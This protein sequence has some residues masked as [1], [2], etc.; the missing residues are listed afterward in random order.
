MRITR[1]SSRR[2]AARASATSSDWSRRSCRSRTS[3]RVRRIP[4]RALKSARLID[5][6]SSRPALRLAPATDERSSGSHLKSALFI[7]ERAPAIADNAV[8]AAPNVAA[9]L[10]PLSTNAAP[11]PTLE[12][13]AAPRPTAASHPAAPSRPVAALHP[14]APPRTAASPR[15]VVAPLASDRYFLKITLSADARVNLD[16]ARDLLRHVLPSG[17]PALIVEPALTVLSGPQRL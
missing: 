17:D 1:R 5:E 7:D 11:A 4:A 9:R 8:A 3:R 12:R 13:A 6:T 2:R 14:A 10:E 15:A 16:R